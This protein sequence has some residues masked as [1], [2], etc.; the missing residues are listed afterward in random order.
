M[1][2]YIHT[3]E[4]VATESTKAYYPLT[5]ITTVNNE[6]WSSVPL[7][8]VNNVS[9][10]SVWGV[11]CATFNWWNVLWRSGSSNSIGTISVW[12][13]VT[14]NTWWT[15]IAYQ[16]NNSNYP[17]GITVSVVWDRTI[18]LVLIYS[19]ATRQL[20]SATWIATN[21]WHNIVVVYWNGSKLY[22]DNTLQASHTDTT[23]GSSN[24]FVIWWG[25]QG[26]PYSSF[27]W[28]V[29][30]VIWENWER[31]TNYISYY[32]NWIKNKYWIS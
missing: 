13:Y 8:N 18:R 3:D 4:W 12:I 24:S 17:T 7:I 31:D 16:S 21:W 2:V 5:S 25:M 20:N 28:S 30:N 29:S 6:A 19:N 26:N 22:V 23:T 15:F 10:G 14:D 11:D 1:W 32:Y 9:F 27:N